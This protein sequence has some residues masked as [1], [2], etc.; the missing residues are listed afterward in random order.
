MWCDQRI[1][2]CGR[3]ATLFGRQRV[4]LARVLIA[5]AGTM[6]VQWMQ[7]RVH[8]SHFKHSNEQA[9]W[10]HSECDDVTAL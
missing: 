9:Y 2:F 4:T 8:D 1:E 6:V 3:L 10:W 7:R 5:F